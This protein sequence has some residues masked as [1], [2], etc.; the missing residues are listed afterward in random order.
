MGHMRTECLKGNCQSVV[1]CSPIGHCLDATSQ[2][3]M[4]IKVDMCYVIP[5]QSIVFPALLQLED[6]HDVDIAY[7]TPGLL[8]T[9]L[10]S[11]SKPS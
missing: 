2:V 1:M 7:S 11:S 4:N 5:K 3:R 6:G 9:L 10:K 8:V